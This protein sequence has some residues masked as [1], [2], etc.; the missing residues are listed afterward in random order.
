MNK[1]GFLFSF[2]F[3]IFSFL[4]IG[5]VRAYTYQGINIDQNFLDNAW[6]LLEGTRYNNRKIYH[7]EDF[8]YVYLSYYNSSK[9][10]I[11]FLPD[12]T[13]YTQKSSYIQIQSTVT[14]TSTYEFAPAV[15]YNKSNGTFE[16][17]N[18][19]NFYLYNSSGASNFD[20]YNGNTKV[21]SKAF[22][23]SLAPQNYVINFHL[24]GSEVFDTSDI[25]NINK[26]RLKFNI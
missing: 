13:F 16:I 7:Q 10:M 20:V 14:S 2:L 1:K 8:P 21:W 19:N 11:V 26:F 25:I 18:A 23:Y 12:F 5:K 3:F 4:F 22:D 17:T 15:I 6:N 9:F 24:N